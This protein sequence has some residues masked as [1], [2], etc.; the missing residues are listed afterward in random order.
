MMRDPAVPLHRQDPPLRGYLLLGGLSLFWGLAWPIMKVAL[1]EIRPWTF[2]AVSLGLGA[3]GLM[4]LARSRGLRLSIPR[5][6]MIPLALVSLLN[7]TGWHLC[8]AHGIA[9][10]QAGRAV[11]IGFTMSLW[12]AILA[13]FVLGER[14]SAWRIFALVTGLCGLG[15]L[16]LPD[17]KAVGTAP[18]GALFMLMAA[19]SWGA[20]T[21]FMKYFRWTVPVMVLT[22]WQLALGSIPVIAGALL[23]EDL[24]VLT[25]VSWKAWLAMVYVILFPMLF[26]HWAWFSVVGLFPASVAAIGT[27]AIPVVGVLS[28]ALMLGESLGI[29]EISALSI[30]VLSVGIVLFSRPATSR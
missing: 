7:I 16:I 11:I 20:G 8:S 3:V 28:S 22:G 21:V 25:Q 29:R 10:M 30:V 13:R 1:N 19:L 23:L 4:A 27:L 15:I 26:C 24:S 6:E 2:R 12:A 5:S 18:L 14:L 17:L 9:R